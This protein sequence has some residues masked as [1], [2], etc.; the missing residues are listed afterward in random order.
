MPRYNF[1]YRHPY[2]LGNADP[3]KTAL[4]VRVFNTR[5]ASG[6]F[7]PGL[8]FIP[9]PCMSCNKTKRSELT[10]LIA[11]KGEDKV[12]VQTTFLHDDCMHSL[13]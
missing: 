2:V 5:K 8:P 9:L 10:E 12:P 3:N 7:A 11:R 13:T 6:V 1:E 4:S